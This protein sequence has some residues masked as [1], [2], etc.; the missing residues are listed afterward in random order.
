MAAQR[1][2]VE[3]DDGPVSHGIKAA[4]EQIDAHFNGAA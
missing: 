1:P 3:F 2:V 4:W